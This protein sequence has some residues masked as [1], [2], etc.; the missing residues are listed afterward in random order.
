MK[1]KTKIQFRKACK[2]AIFSSANMEGVTRS[3]AHTYIYEGQHQDGY[4][5]WNNFKTPTEALEDFFRFVECR[6]KS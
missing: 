4:G 3:L 5:F 2:A 6:V 1:R